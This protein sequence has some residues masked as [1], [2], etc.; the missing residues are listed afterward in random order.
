VEWIAKQPYIKVLRE[1][2][3]LEQTDVE[4]ERLLYLYPDQLVTKHRTFPITEVLD[5][6]YREIAGQGGLLYLH[7]MSGVYSYIVKSSPNNFIEVFK[8]QRKK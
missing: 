2:N 1:V 8:Q 3:G 6:S 7:T 5:I 4:D